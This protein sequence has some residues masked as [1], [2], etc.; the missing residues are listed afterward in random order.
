MLSPSH[1]TSGGGAFFIWG[2][3]MQKQALPVSGASTILLVV[4]VM[5]CACLISLAQERGFKS[6]F[7][8][9]DLSGWVYGLRQGTENKHGVGYQVAKG[10]IY[11]TSEDGGNLFTEKEYGDF[12]LRF[13][14]KL[15]PNA[16]NGIG[17]RSPL[18]GDAAYMGMEIQVLDDSGS[19]YESL[20]PAQ[21]HGSIYDVVAAKRGS[22][23][24]VGEWNSEE[25][26]AKGRRITVKLNGNAIVDANLDDVK[27]EAVLK[28]HP[29]LARTKGHIGF[30][31]HGSRVEF[32]NLRI[33]EL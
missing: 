29:G 12:V 18:E 2:Q 6:L 5:L 16:N 17:I 1:V 24:P 11:C 15:E 23:K 19:D 8:G 32:R 25:I 9:K 33:K 28:K 7:N 13:E 21:Y 27:D 31:G 14:F 20:R 30:L 3:E 26:T 10:I 4:S 22:L